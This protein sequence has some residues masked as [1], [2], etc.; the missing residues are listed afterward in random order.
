ME[1]ANGSVKSLSSFM[2]MTSVDI[3][4]VFKEIV[5]NWWEIGKN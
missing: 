2:I 3:L 1:A 5:A 4:F